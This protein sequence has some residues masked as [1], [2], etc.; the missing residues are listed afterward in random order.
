MRSQTA[1][2]PGNPGRFLLAALDG[3]RG[4]AALA[5]LAH[6]IDFMSKQAMLCQYAFLPMIDI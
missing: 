5:A 1:S 2:D 6:H 3:L 4:V